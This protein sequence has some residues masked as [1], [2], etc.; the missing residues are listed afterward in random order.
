MNTYKDVARSLYAVAI[1]YLNESEGRIEGGERRVI[2]GQN[3]SRLEKM[4]MMTGL[5]ALDVLINMPT[6]KETPNKRIVP[7][8]QTQNNLA[9]IID[10]KPGVFL[11][12]L[13]GVQ[14]RTKY[15]FRFSKS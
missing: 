6:I 13:S 9:K 2:H 15:Y 4:A 8:S 11:S 1:L 7:I 14:A 12:Y 10:V 3:G 5:L